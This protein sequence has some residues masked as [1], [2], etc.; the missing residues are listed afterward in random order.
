MT[1]DQIESNI[2]RLAGNISE[3]SFPYELLTAYGLPKA[4]ITRLKNGTYNL[5]KQEPDTLWNEGAPLLEI[6]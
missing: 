5:A 1:I 3:Q 2:Q 4:A 6:L